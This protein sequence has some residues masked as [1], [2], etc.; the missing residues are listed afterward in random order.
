MN[1]NTIAQA[2]ELIERLLMYANA[3]KVGYGLNDNVLNETIENAEKFIE[4][5]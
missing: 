3:L 1:E 4:E 5:N 2:K